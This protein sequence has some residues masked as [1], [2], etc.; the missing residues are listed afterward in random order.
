YNGG[1]SINNVKINGG[2]ITAANI[3]SNS[4]ATGGLI[5][6]ALHTAINNCSTNVKVIGSNYSF[7][8]GG[9][10]GQFI[11]QPPSLTLTTATISGCSTSGD[12]YGHDVG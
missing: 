7:A 11:E 5:G 12:V 10:V 3:N 4:I 2:V 9:L 8:T 1:P 6:L